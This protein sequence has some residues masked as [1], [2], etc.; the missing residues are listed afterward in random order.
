[1]RIATL[2]AAALPMLLVATTSFCATFKPISRLE[3][4]DQRAVETLAFSLLREPAIQAA[5]EAAIQR[6]EASRWWQLE[7]GKKTLQGA[8]DELLWGV[9]LAAASDPADP[10]I[11][12]TETLPRKVGTRDIPGSRYAGDSPDRIYRGAA[13]DPAYRYEIRG[14]QTT[15]KD[16]QPLYFSIEAIPRPAFWG[17]PPLAV[18]TSKDVDV[19]ADGSFTITV[20]AAPTEGRRNH[21]QLPPKAAM[22][23]LRDTTPDWRQQATKLSIKRIDDAPAKPRSRDA[24][25]KHASELLDEAVTASTKY[26]EGISSRPANQ[27]DTFVRDLGWGILAVNDF[28]LAD[29]E[30]LLITIDP[31]SARYLSLQVMD[32]WLRSVPYRNRTTA[33]NDRQAKANADGSFTYVLS[34]RDPG[35]Y[36]WIDSGLNDGVMVIRWE[37]LTQQAEADKAVRECR[38]LKLSE[39][40]AALPAEVKR[41]TPAE[42]KKQLAQRQS[43]YETRLH[44]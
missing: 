36:N 40:A 24:I 39:L 41:V 4:P 2:A 17:L 44:E 13:V 21:L 42:R 25:V 35:V 33:L 30:A 1:M 8:T 9:L 34:K 15:R 11:V 43:A 12:W 27:L 10:K 31:V 3:T 7:D 32:P 23:L 22:L 6:Y 20:D 16:K 14:H 18:I 26:Y 28:S 5:R 19:G 29:D 38:K 37:L